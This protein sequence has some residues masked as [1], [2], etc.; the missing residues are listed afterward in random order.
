MTV[1]EIAALYPMGRSAEQNIRHRLRLLELP[2]EVQIKVHH[3]KLSQDA[4][5]KFLKKGE[6]AA[7]SESA[8]PRRKE[9][10]EHNEAPST[11]Q[12]DVRTV[13]QDFIARLKAIDIDGAPPA[14]P[15]E[16]LLLADE[17]RRM[18]ATLEERASRQRLAVAR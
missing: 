18:L 8:K 11:S 9:P 16:F 6:G 2:P 4:A 3:G 1:K 5:L 12:D 15:D 14:N 7:R 17:A 10:N 13:L